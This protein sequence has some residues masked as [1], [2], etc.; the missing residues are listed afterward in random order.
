MQHKGNIALLYSLY[1]AVLNSSPII[2][3]SEENLDASMSIT[4]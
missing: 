3:T 4:V 2:T 1:Q